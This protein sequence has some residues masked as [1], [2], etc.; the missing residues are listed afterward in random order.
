MLEVFELFAGF[1]CCGE[2]ARFQSAPAQVRLDFADYGIS[3]QPDRVRRTRALWSV[4]LK[5]KVARAL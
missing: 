3:A 2:P 1:E 5:S 4:I